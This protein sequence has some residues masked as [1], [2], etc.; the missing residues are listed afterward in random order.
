MANRIDF[1]EVKSRVSIDAVLTRYD[2]RLR[3]SGKSLRG[4]CPIPCDQ[5]GGKSCFSVD[6]GKGGGVWKCFHQGC[7]AARQGGDVL[8]LVKAVEGCSLREAGVKLAEW[9]GVGEPQPNDAGTEAESE[10]TAEGET[11]S[12]GRQVT[13]GVINPPLG[14]ELKAVDRQAALEYARSRGLSEETAER[15]GLAVS[16]GGRFKDRL[17]IPL[18]DQ[19]GTLVA[20]AGRVLDG[21]EPKYLFPPSERGFHKSYL[22]F[23]L[24][25]VLAENGGGRNV[26]LVEGFFDCMVVNQAG[27]P[28]LALMG[29]SLSEQQTELLA[30]HFRHVV[31]VLDGD[32]A[33]R[34]GTEECLV[35]L[36]RRVYVRAV[37]LPEG[38]APDGMP[39]AE[40]RKALRY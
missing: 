17:V 5:E 33:G 22:L 30:S 40:I 12:V 15:F 6:P 3:K 21:G 25:R 27:F 28:A 4:S 9:F 2:V 14:F 1:T 29:S 8:D 36:G 31:V 10:P 26:V 34:K 24:H 35:K 7:D 38:Q 20:Y 32:E 19:E 11:C 18:H 37:E 39:P 23:N 16:E 13:P